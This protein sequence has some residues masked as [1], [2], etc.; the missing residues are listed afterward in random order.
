MPRS[1]GALT[2]AAAAL[3]GVASFAGVYAWMDHAAALQSQEQAAAAA[4]AVIHSF[5]GVNVEAKSAIVIDLKT[6]RI[7]YEKDPDAQLPLAS[8]TKVAMALAVSEVLDLNSKITIPYDTAYAGTPPT[9]LLKGEEW[10]VRDVMNFTLIASSN[11]GADIL[12]AAANAALHAKYP[13]SPATGV[14]DA[15]VWRMNQIA[16]SLGLGQTYFLNTN[17][18][19]LSTTQSGAYSSARDVAKLLAY[20][21]STSPGLFVATS[22][23]DLTLTDMDG[24]TASAYNTN[25]AL[26]DIPGL[27]LGKTGYT[28]LAGGNLGVV[29]DVGLSHPVV[30]V[31]LGS[32][33]DGR[34]TDMKTLVAAAR[35][36]VSHEQ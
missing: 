24:D 30:A 26:G 15:T 6:G 25:E 33:Y 21:A 9:R 3:I 35:D 16:Q 2:V 5:D 32:S 36:A 29:F 31:V 17:G 10:T 19:D 27:I 22:K 7:L 13:Q 34:F 14:H 20:A 28:D 23:N 12:S 4:A 8:I 1:T 11:E 18:L